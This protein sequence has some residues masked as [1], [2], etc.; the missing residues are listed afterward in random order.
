MPSDSLQ[1]MVT[2]A[3]PCAC[4]YE[5]RNRIIKVLAKGN[6]IDSYGEHG[7]RVDERGLIETF[8]GTVPDRTVFVY[9]SAVTFRVRYTS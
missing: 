9:S 8:Q 6:E 1:S 3:G 4:R 2:C 7:G 5:G